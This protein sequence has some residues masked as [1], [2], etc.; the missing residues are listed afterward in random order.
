MRAHLASVLVKGGWGG[1]GGVVRIAVAVAVAVVLPQSLSAPAFCSYRYLAPTS[2]VCPVLLAVRYPVLSGAE[3]LGFYAVVRAYRFT[4][5]AA[6]LGHIGLGI[7]C[8]SL[9]PPFFFFF[10]HSSGCI[11]LYLPFYPLI[12]L[13]TL[14]SAPPRATPRATLLLLRLCGVPI[15]TSI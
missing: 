12:P 1:G 15:P 8:Y 13:Y 6:V 2:M 14:G 4:G 7:L 11:M 5:L 9:N 3:F 10:A